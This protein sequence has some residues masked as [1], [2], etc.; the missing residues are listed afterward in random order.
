MECCEDIFDILN[1]DEEDDDDDNENIIEQYNEDFNYIDANIDE[2]EMMMIEDDDMADDKVKNG[3]R[4]SI[5]I[6][7][8]LFFR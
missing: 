8:S 1:N 6:E 4:F 3:F 7:Y 2:E 5:K